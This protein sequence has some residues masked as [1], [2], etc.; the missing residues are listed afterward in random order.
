[1]DYEMPRF[2]RDR[3]Q[4]PLNRHLASIVLVVYGAVLSYGMYVLSQ[5]LVEVCIA[6]SRMPQDA[7]RLSALGEVLRTASL[8]L[9]LFTAV[10]LYLTEDIGEIVKLDS[11]FP[12]KRTSRYSHEIIIACF[13]V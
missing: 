10:M 11:V 3:I 6:Y 2:E 7:N 1:M 13:Y 8:Q 12:H 4:S 5:V 9:V